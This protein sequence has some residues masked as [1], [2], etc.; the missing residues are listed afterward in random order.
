[1]RQEWLSEAAC[2]R[3]Q[4]YTSVNRYQQHQYR[5]ERRRPALAPAAL[6]FGV[7]A[8]AAG[9]AGAAGVLAVAGVG[10]VLCAA[11]IAFAALPQRS[12]ARAAAAALVLG[13]LLILA[14]GA[15]Y[16]RAVNSRP[17]QLGVPVGYVEQ[18][19]GIVRGDCHPG[20]DGTV[21]VE[22]IL[23]SAAAPSRQIQRVSSFGR[24]VLE[25]RAEKGFYHGEVLLVE[26]L[27]TGFRDGRGRLWYRVSERRVR[28]LGFVSAPRRLRAAALQRTAES[29][30]VLGRAPRRLFA[31]LVLGLRQDLAPAEVQRFRTAGAM[32]VLALSGMHLGILAALCVAFVKPLFGKRAAVLTASAGACAYVLLVGLRPSL[33]RALLMYLPAAA[34]YLQ[35]RR[36]D[37][38]GVL[39]AAFVGVVAIDPLS[40]NT[41]SFQL[42][43][44][45]L[46]GIALFAGP[47]SRC[48]QRRLP[49]L[50][51]LPLAAAVSAQLVTAPFLAAGFEVLHP[52]GIISS[53]VLVPLVTAFL[54]AS[55]ISWAALTLCVTA[56]LDQRL[57]VA[58]LRFLPERLYQLLTASAE[59]FSA[60]PALPVAADRLPWVIGVLTAALLLRYYHGTRAGR[61]HTHRE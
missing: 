59:L 17:A 15:G 45:A 11:G 50:V 37:L 52:I 18:L 43:F 22:L 19:H 31:A 40:L 24:V 3:R 32:H 35:G 6:V 36:V 23:Q 29:M 46:A 60:A 38:V 57:L 41:L 13:L 42:S 39:A 47:I 44:A 48:L 34:A 56:G 8:A 53:L 61:Q 5:L 33:L 30:Q 10:S 21:R 2:R 49:A 4:L 27:R 54:W 7:A 20:L 51:A 28:R 58:L 55:M 9:S 16:R 25:L 26:P 14:A 12:G 1:M